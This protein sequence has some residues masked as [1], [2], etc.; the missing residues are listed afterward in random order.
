VQRARYIHRVIVERGLEAQWIASPVCCSC[1]LPSE[2]ILCGLCEQA[3]R[4][5]REGQRERLRQE[6]EDVARELEA[7][8]IHLSGAMASA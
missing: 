4:D 7:E 2:G 1:G 8:G 3:E 6:N 5:D